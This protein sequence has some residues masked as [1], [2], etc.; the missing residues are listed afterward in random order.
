MPMAYAKFV[1]SEQKTTI[2][3]ITGYE[4]SVPRGTVVNPFFEREVAFNG[5]VQL[6]K[7]IDE[8]QDA[9]HFPQRTM[10]TRQFGDDARHE[11]PDLSY[12]TQGPPPPNEHPIASFKLSILFRHNASWQGSVIWIEKGLQSEFRSAL[13]LILLL[14]SVLGEQKTTNL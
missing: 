5:A 13:E 2:V 8:L 3:R 7:I 12:L 10:E 9:I 11:P 1:P 4:D 14:D 6:L